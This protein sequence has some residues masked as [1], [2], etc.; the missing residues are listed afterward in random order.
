MR[1]TISHTILLVST[2]FM[3][4]STTHTES[5]DGHNQISNRTAISRVLYGEGF[6]RV[7]DTGISLKFEDEILFDGLDVKG[8]DNCSF[9]IVETFSEGIYVDRYEVEDIERQGGPHVHFF[10]KIDLELPSYKSEQNIVLVYYHFNPQTVAD[11]SVSITLP[12]HLRYQ[13]PSNS[14]THRKVFINEPLVYLTCSPPEITQSPHM[15][16]NNWIKLT[17]TNENLRLTALVPVGQRQSE[18]IVSV[19]TLIVTIAGTLFIIQEI[20]KKTKQKVK[21]E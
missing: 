5:V 3:I 21:T 14:V 12:V 2:L 8:Y 1:P 10:S 17:P 7:L 4:F 9:M 18:R 13:R 16:P 11:G 15:V 20:R 19:G 6:H